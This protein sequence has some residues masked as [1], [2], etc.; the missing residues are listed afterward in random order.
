MREVSYWVRGHMT[1]LQG[2]LLKVVNQKILIWV[3]STEDCHRGKDG[4]VIKVGKCMDRLPEKMWL[5]KE[6]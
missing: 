5:W 3:L 4:H 1:S 2:N 6:E